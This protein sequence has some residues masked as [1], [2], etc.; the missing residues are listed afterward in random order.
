MKLKK[1]IK[2]ARRIWFI[3]WIVA[4][5][6]AYFVWLSWSKLTDLIGDSNVIWFILLGIFIILILVGWFNFKKGLEKFK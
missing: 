2:R 4:I 1:T 3:S 5:T 6:I